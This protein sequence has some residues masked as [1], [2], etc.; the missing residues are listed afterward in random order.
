MFRLVFCL[1]F[2]ILVDAIDVTWTTCD[3][4][5]L[6]LEKDDLS[7]AGKKIIGGV[8]M[9]EGVGQECYGTSA[10]TPLRLGKERKRRGRGIAFEFDKPSVVKQ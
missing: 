4:E 2:F 7:K 10:T 6:D 3:D 9:D 5:E 1:T 8:R